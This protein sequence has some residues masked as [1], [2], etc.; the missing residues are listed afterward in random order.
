LDVWGIHGVGGAWGAIA[1]GIFA[2]EVGLIAGNSAQLLVQVVGVAATMAYS[3]VVTYIILKVVDLSIGLR[4]GAKEE[5]IGLDIALHAEE[6]Y[7]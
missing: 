4:V 2:V 5:E 3:M 7:V 1:T 6:A